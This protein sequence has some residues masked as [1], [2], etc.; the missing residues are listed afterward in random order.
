MTYLLDVNALLAFGIFDHEFHERVAGWIRGLR[1][2]G[3]LKLATCSITEIGFVRI[4][5]QTPRYRFTT[6][7]ARSLLLQI[8]RR[9]AAVFT[10]VPDFND[11]ALL[12]GWVRSPKQV[13]DGHL[14]QL[15]KA[16]NAVLATLDR[17]IPGA[18]L[19]PEGS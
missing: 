14:L 8:K 9:D 2:K 4:V 18:F 12:P 3:I 10:F 7:E 19:I 13:T 17:K 5:G 1:S 11:I 16:N 15:A 6:A